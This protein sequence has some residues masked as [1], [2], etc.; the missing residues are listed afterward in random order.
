[1]I[2][3]AQIVHALPGRVR[4]RIG[5]RRHDYAYFD[6]LMGK[7]ADVAGVEVIDTNPRT[8]SVLLSYEG[9]A[10][11]ALA[12]HALEQG[13]FVL[14]LEAQSAKE[15]VSQPAE[16]WLT[17]AAIDWRTPFALALLGLAFRQMVAGK[18]M[19]PAISLFWYAYEVLERIGR[20]R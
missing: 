15:T 5:S 14:D 20:K 19:A 16:A 17:R 10:L 4:L 12:A 3:R 13:L 7:L 11:A 8:G 1:M 9:D 18:V 2:A 6:E